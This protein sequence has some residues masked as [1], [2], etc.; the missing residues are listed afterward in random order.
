MAEQTNPWGRVGDDGTV[1][2]RIDDQ[3]V[4]VGAYPDGSPDE[5]LAMF[6]RKFDDLEAQVSLAE[7]R[8]RANAP[9]RD[10]QRG[11]K[12]VASELETPSG[13]GDYQALRARVATLL[14]E[15]DTVA[16]KQAKERE[17]ALEQAIAEREAIVVE[18]EVLA[19]KDSSSLRWKETTTAMTDLF[20]RWKSHQANG[21]KLPKATADALWKRFRTAR[22]TLDR[23]RRQHFQE[24]DK[25]NKEVKST[26]R[27]LIE[28]AEALA[29][30]GADGIGAYRALL[31]AWKKAPRGNRSVED[32]LWARFKAAGDVLYQA[33]SQQA[34]AEDEA[35]RD[36]G[37][38][39]KALVEEF[40][41]ILALTDHR[42]A[43]DRLRVFH[44][45]FRQIGPAPRSMVKTLDSEIKK[46]DQHVKKLEAEHWEKTD[47]EKEARSQSFLGQIDQQIEQLEAQKAKAE[48]AGDARTAQAL[49][50]E[51][52]TKVA[53]K[54]VLTDA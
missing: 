41:D 13:V 17:Q 36:N 37:E 28:K 18:M 52:E 27:E 43:L 6:V 33:K 26:K 47:P 3:W 1:E 24:R 53:W 48:A 2:V 40:R 9:A 44:D 51:I 45:R 21:P 46:F 5:A 49:A 38:A 11:V 23:A 34:E 7:Q 31:D 12:K 10:I 32:Q 50:D 8:L 29:P 20:D 19:A 54:R 30:K 35:N 22:G 15:L 4:A 16:E 14:T 39:K 25:V 42:Q